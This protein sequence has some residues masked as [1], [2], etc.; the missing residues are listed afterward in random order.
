MFEQFFVSIKRFFFFSPQTP[1]EDDDEAAVLGGQRL[2]R[3]NNA[4]VLADPVLQTPP[5]DPG[6]IQG[7]HILTTK[8]LPVRREKKLESSI[9]SPEEEEGVECSAFVPTGDSSPIDPFTTVDHNIIL[10]TTTTC[11]PCQEIGE[12]LERSATVSLDEVTKVLRWEGCAFV[13]SRGYNRPDMDSAPSIDPVTTTTDHDT[14]HTTTCEPCQTIQDS[15]LSDDPSSSTGHDSE[16]SEGDHQQPEFQLDER[17]KT[18]SEVS[19]V[20]LDRHVPECCPT[21]S[22]DV[23]CE[24]EFSTA[25][26]PPCPGRSS[27]CHPWEY[28]VDTDVSGGCEGVASPLT[29]PAASLQGHSDHHQSSSPPRTS[30]SNARRAAAPVKSLFVA[31]SP[32]LPRKRP[33]TREVLVPPIQCDS[34]TPSKRHCKRSLTLEERLVHFDH[35]MD[36]ARDHFDDDDDLDRNCNQGDLTYGKFLTR[37]AE[38]LAQHLELPDEEDWDGPRNQIFVDFG[39]GVGNAVLQT[40]ETRGHCLI[41]SR[42]IEVV[43]DRFERSL[44]YWQFLDTPGVNLVLGDLT[45]PVHRAF[46]TQGGI[47]KAFANNFDGFWSQK[48]HRTSQDLSKPSLDDYLAGLFPHMVPGSILVTLS[49]LRLGISQ[50]RATELEQRHGWASDVRRS[51]F[52]EERIVLGKRGEIFSWNEAQSDTG[53]AM[54]YKYTR[55]DQSTHDGGGPPSSGNDTA[56]AAA[57]V[58]LCC[59]PSCPKCIG[60]VPIPATRLEAGTGKLLINHCDGC[61][62]A[63]RTLRNRKKKWDIVKR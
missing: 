3:G 55:L 13:D 1:A 12:K 20:V 17:G 2:H 33:S 7:D 58:F 53:P 22:T 48:S 32:I 54:A 31:P 8:V 27:A 47:I 15:S 11:E 38:A 42:G 30:T 56:T 45:D 63:T 4:V 51:F 41:E 43:V 24:V 61:N 6:M 49:P 19:S 50:T 9:V 16:G 46:L 44:E 35:H 60:A 26:R 40:A 14:L 59:T 10:R 37:G 21:V 36:K 28:W 23:G 29:S 18:A 57:A 5:T 34:I 62:V 52:R 25:S 39:H